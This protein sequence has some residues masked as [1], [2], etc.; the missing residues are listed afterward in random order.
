MAKRR[1]RVN[2]PYKHRNRFRVFVVRPDGGRDARSFDTEAEAQALVAS[3]QKKLAGDILLR[4][5][6]TEYLAYIKATGCRQVTLDNSERFL[7]RFFGDK[8]GYPLRS[9]TPAKAQSL[10]ASLQSRKVRGGR[11]GYAAK[12]HRMFLQEARRFGAFCVKKKWL[13]TNTLAEVEPV[14]R[15]KAGKEKL[16]SDEARILFD[17]CLSK[18]AAGEWQALIP[19]LCLGL[20]LRAG[21]VAHL[22][23]RHVNEQGRLLY[24]TEA[25]THAGNRKL[26]VH[27]TIAACLRHQ[28]GD[29]ASGQLLPITVNIVYN[30]VRRYCR[31][32]GVKVVGPHALRG[33]HADLA[34]TRGATSALLMAA[35][36]HTNINVTK[37][38]YLGAGT[39]DSA[40]AQEAMR[41]LGQPIDVIPDDDEDNE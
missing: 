26:E 36:G 31:L 30:Q 40:Q 37:R 20:G 29:R 19:I 3:L 17:F 21:E 18:F 39:L 12:S 14:G 23:V 27:D 28:V 13:K 35:M 25:K 6:V 32:A 41:R 8:T 4:D 38:H 11:D 24:V 34:A 33:T 10:Y 1:V 16:T 2:G 7:K 9:I 5:A 15:A 22:E